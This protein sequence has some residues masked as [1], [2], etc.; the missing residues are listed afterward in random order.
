[1][2]RDEAR[3]WIAATLGPGETTAFLLDYLEDAWESMD[4][5]TECFGR[6]QAR[7]LLLAHVGCTFSGDFSE[8][9]HD[10]TNQRETCISIRK[11]EG[12]EPLPCNKGIRFP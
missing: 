9:T 7:A 11:N 2:T 8:Q 12:A 3:A 10:R 5:L 6:E 1:M 4:E